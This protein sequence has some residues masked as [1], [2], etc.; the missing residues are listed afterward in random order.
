M[1][2]RTL[3]AIVLILMPSLRAGG[4]SAGESPPARVRV[5]GSKLILPLVEAWG[6]QL[7]ERGIVVEAQGR[8][9][10]T[11]PPALL[12]GRAD[13]ASMS[14]PMQR[15]ELDAFRRR[16][17]RNPTPIPVAI[18]AVA[19]VVHVSNPLERLTL[20]E[21]DAIFSMTRYCGS[22]ASLSSWGDLGLSGEWAGRSI[23]LYG[24][25]WSSATQ[26]FMRTVA[27]CGGL[28]RTDVRAIP[29]GAS[30]VK[31]IVESRYGIGYVSRARVTAEV[32]LLALARSGDEPFLTPTRESVAS[33]AYPL[34]RK[35]L[36]YVSPPRDGEISPAV[37]AFIRHVL[38]K[39]GRAVVE[40]H[41]YVPPP[42]ESV[43]A[44][45]AVLGD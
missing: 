22:A 13:V 23:G 32:K 40:Q 7:A 19:V 35:L 15:A 37:A 25:D 45:L 38:S 9:S 2:F 36:L 42:P 8:G 6:R 31:S 29:G 43:A 33:G 24:G 10:S 16:F 5:A 44:S 4:D 20:P 12:V 26:A 3:F 11:G 17:D 18:D 30:L 28:F 1:G 21:L 14:H 39:P 34:S 41:G 27:L